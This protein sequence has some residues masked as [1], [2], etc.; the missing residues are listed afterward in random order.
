MCQIRIPSHYL[1]KQHIAL[2]RT[3][4]LVVSQVRRGPAF[5]KYCT[6]T[7]AA[8]AEDLEN[9]VVPEIRFSSTR[10]LND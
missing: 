9:V 2:L 6:V 4:Y 10:V 5:R 1:Y 3:S 8:P 7:V